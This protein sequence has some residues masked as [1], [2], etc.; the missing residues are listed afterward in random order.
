[1][2]V[3]LGPVGRAWLSWW[4]VLLLVAV[5]V[6]MVLPLAF[7]WRRTWVG[8]LDAPTAALLVLLGGFLLRFVI[9]FSSEGIRI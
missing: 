3:S 5:I 8:N 2:I 4:G 6:G 7:Y 1:M 9:V